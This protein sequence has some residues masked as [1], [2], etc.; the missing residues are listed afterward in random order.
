VGRRRVSADARSPAKQALSQQLG[1]E[2][3]GWLDL[4]WPSAWAS[5]V[6]SVGC[7]REKKEDAG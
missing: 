7:V 6:Q 2:G 1:T 4:G 5:K 3:S